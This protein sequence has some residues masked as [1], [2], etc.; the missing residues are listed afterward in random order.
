MNQTTLKAPLRFGGVGVHSGE[1]A[2]LL[3]QPAPADHGVVIARR[4]GSEL[5]SYAATLEHVL[6][7]RLGTTLGLSPE[8][9]VMVSEHV[10]S[11]LYGLGVDNARLEVDGPEMPVLDGSALPFAQAIQAAGLCDLGAPRRVLEIIE[12]VEFEIGG[13]RAGF[14]PAEAFELAVTIEYDDPAIGRQTYEGPATGQ[15]FME[16]IAPARTFGYAAELEAL[17]AAG[18]GRGASLE[19]AVAFEN[20]KALNPEGLRFPDE[21]VRHKALDAI[22]DLALAGAALKGRFRAYRPGH[23][24]NAEALRRLFARPETWRMTTQA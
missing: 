16:R 14:E 1:P 23:A 18:R 17:R 7:S 19:N 3:I 4:V 24:V 6:D 10:L 15:A 12:A 20:G 11:A 5:I 8:N 21:P 2:V 13:S 9:A 22:G